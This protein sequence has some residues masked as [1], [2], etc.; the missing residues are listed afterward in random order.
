MF[1]VDGLEQEETFREFFRFVTGD[2]PEPFDGK[3]FRINIYYCK[4]FPENRDRCDNT[5]CTFAT[6]RLA[7]ELGNGSLLKTPTKQIV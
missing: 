4:A 5:Y 6:C 3:S 1:E 2:L 7:K